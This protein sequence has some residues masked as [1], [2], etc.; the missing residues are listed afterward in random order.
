MV[1]PA[2]LLTEGLVAAMVK[3]KDWQTKIVLVVGNGEVKGMD[4]IVYHVIFEKIARDVALKLGATIAQFM[5]CSSDLR[6]LQLAAMLNECGGLDKAPHVYFDTM[7]I[8]SKK[9]CI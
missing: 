5:T 3:H 4:K 1:H 7:A 6:Q 9:N 8:L 2:E